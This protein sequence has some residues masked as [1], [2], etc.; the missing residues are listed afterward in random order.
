MKREGIFCDKN[1]GEGRKNTALCPNVA[2]GKCIS[3]DQDVCAK[4]GCERG[5]TLTLH[6]AVPGTSSQDLLAEGS[7]VVCTTCVNKLANQPFLFKETVIP[8]LLNNVSDAVKSALAAEAL[9]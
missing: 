6:R 1:D 5:I 8:V 9:K 4:H 2:V 3:C 7:V